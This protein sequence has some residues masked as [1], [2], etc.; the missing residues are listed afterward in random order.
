MEENNK[1]R[2]DQEIYTQQDTVNE[3]YAPD[4]DADND[5]KARFKT[6]NSFGLRFATASFINL[7]I[8]IA[9]GLIL[10]GHT[11]KFELF[12]RENLTLVAT[13]L[14]NQVLL[15]IL[16][17]LCLHKVPKYDFGKTKFSVGKYFT[18]L[19]IAYGVGIAGSLIGTVA[20]FLITGEFVNMA[21]NAVGGGN[22]LLRILV[23]CIGAPVAEELVFRKFV[24]D[25]LSGYS[26]ALAIFASG[27]FFGIFHANFQQLFFAM[28]LG[29]VFAYIY[30]ETGNIL[31]TI[32]YHMIINTISSVVLIEI[33]NRAPGNPK[34]LVIMVLLEML[35][36]GTALAGIGLLIAFRKRIK[37]TNEVK[38]PGSRWDF[39]KS[40]G[41]WAFI[42]VGVLLFINTY[43]SI[44]G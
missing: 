7:A 38:N 12:G 39:F 40:Y 3:Q 35:I 22:L 15:V 33:M 16:F 5:K 18:G 1:I 36:F 8:Q 34:L 20:N 27:L 43:I 41:M 44:K 4:I 17:Y 13:F 9:L 42:V 2:S 32:S 28:F 30:A 14:I 26:K 25:R 10:K 11:D 37:I 19:C 6:V 23:V 31:I 21:M 29:W 24:V